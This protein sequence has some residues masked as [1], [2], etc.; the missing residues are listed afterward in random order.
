MCLV[1][2]EFPG[3]ALQEINHIPP[4]LSLKDHS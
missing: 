2:L 1:N 4:E 3:N